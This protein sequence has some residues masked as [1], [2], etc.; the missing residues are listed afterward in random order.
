ME[1][2]DFVEIEYSDGSS[3]VVN[4]CDVKILASK[5]DQSKR[6]YVHYWTPGDE[7]NSLDQRTM[8]SMKKF[9]SSPFKTQ[10][11]G[12]YYCKPIATATTNKATD[13]VDSDDVMEITETESTEEIS[14]KSESMSCEQ[15][16]TED[17][18]PAWQPI[19]K[20]KLTQFN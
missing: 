4:R 3:A 13:D 17:N 10:Q 16:E 5:N 20:G 14:C 11:I 15:N 2:S 18:D 8:C 7:S 12:L 6:R 19:D 9:K 1:R